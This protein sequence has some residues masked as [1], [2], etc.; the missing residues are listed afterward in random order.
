MVV[1]LET[2]LV[3]EKPH[4][5]VIVE[6]REAEQWVLKQLE[7]QGFAATKTTAAQ[8]SHISL[9]E[10]DS[11]YKIIWIKTPDDTAGPANETI[12]WLQG[13]DEPVVV[14]T[15][16]LS[17]ITDDRELYQPWI[18]Q[19]TQNTE[20]IDLITE[21]LPHSTLLIGRD[22]IT[23]PKTFAIA[24]LFTE[25]LA[26]QTLLDPD[27]SLGLQTLKSF[28]AAIE[29]NLMSPLPHRLLV[30]GRTHS[31]LD[32]VKKM[33]LTYQR[34]TGKTPA[35]ETLATTAVPL[36]ALPTTPNPQVEQISELAE[37][38]VSAFPFPKVSLGHFPASSSQVPP[39]G[40]QPTPTK[41][42]KKDL[43][44]PPKPIPMVPISLPP[45]P[46]TGFNRSPRQRSSSR[47]SSSAQASASATT[48]TTTSS[49][50][51]QESQPQKPPE[52]EI[53]TQVADLF[54]K[55]RTDHTV[56]RV[57]KLAKTT[58]SVSRKQTHK[59]KLFWAGLAFT[60]V[61]LGVA[62][63]AL[64]F[65]VSTWWLQKSIVR[66]WETQPATSLSSWK[67]PQLAPLAHLVSSQVSSYSL[68]LDES[69]FETQ[70]QLAEAG[71]KTASLPKDQAAYGQSVAKATLQLLGRDSGSSLSSWQAAGL[72]AQALYDQYS[73][74]QAVL[75]SLSKV[76]SDPNQ[77]EQLKKYESWL[78]DQKKALLPS[79]QLQPLM[80]FLLGDGTPR[81]YVVVLQN[82][83]ELRPTGGFIQSVALVTVNQGVITDT[84]VLNAYDIDKKVLGVVTPP[85]DVTRYLGEQ[86]WFLRDANWNPDFPTSS[87]QIAWFVERA[88]GKKIDGVVGLNLLATKELLKAL[89]PL[90]VPEYNEVL[91]DRNLFER[92]E[93]HSEIQLVPESTQQDY[94]TLVLTKLL[95]KL[96][97]MPEDKVTPVLA[98][99]QAQL[100]QNQVLVS[101]TNADE[102]ASLTPLG[103]T[104]T[105]LKPAC[106]TQLSGAPCT[107]DTVAQVESNVGVNKA[108]AYITRKTAH[109]VAL[110]K[111]QITHHRTMSFTNTATTPAWPKGTYKNYLRL[112]VAPEAQLT[113]VSINK[114]PVPADRISIGIENKR[115]V[116][117]VLVEV[118]V[119]QTA[120]VE[121]IY[122]VPSPSQS[123][124]S[125]ALFDQRQ[126]G[127]EDP[128]LSLTFT[129]DQS[130][131]PTLIAPQAQVKDNQIVFDP[132]TLSHSFVGA[133]FN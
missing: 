27:I 123:Q 130:F 70:R 7:I 76:V 62:V 87:N 36:P 118:P 2:Q 37:K 48:Q 24:H 114:V 41:R 14:I 133:Q 58:Q 50:R 56:E 42:T 110:G 112:Y 84:Q 69:L 125:Y 91:T 102:N 109:D 71:L 129:Y 124:F 13:R 63:L 66:A 45:D 47:L 113:S 51:P 57:Q 34:H 1:H 38:I 77:L 95:Q 30:E 127:I 64:L 116:F 11:L 132:V 68:V 78:T 97:Q 3:E 93:F 90:D 5:L 74:T 65:W 53:E 17:P 119:N 19:T 9:P 120:I 10:G 18:Q 49:S 126:S 121:A 103:W 88:T 85:A 106:P 33:Q 73:Q 39:L 86:Q 115:K 80:A 44:G 61:G 46:E 52:A 98:A 25:Y 100:N 89:G 43:V 75:K 108:N 122:H 28:L 23:S 26:N 59:K 67:S 22:V 31:S 32:L 20:F 82:N 131:K 8:V 79:Q 29:P 111:N 40:P 81:T 105:L 35:I 128:G 6:H 99:L 15:T 12:R 104:G 4:V 72:Q 60:G 83:Q 117:G 55:Y 101:L 107:V 96:T 92:M 94:S 54:K 21:Y 16:L